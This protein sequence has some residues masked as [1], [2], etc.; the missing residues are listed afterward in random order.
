MEHFR[1]QYEST[2]YTDYLQLADEGILRSIIENVKAK[3][4]DGKIYK[5]K[6]G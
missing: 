3:I 6:A 4:K 1:N 5:G 2:R